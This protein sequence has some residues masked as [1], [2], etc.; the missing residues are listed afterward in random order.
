M[1]L[2]LLLLAT[3]VSPKTLPDDFTKRVWQT[4]DG[5]PE[6]MVQAFVQ[7]PDHYLWIGTTG[8]LVRFDGARFVVFDRENTPEISENSVFTLAV[9]RDGS[10]WAGPDGGGLLRY[11]DGVFRSYSASSGLLN[12]FV[13]ALYE[14][15][16]GVFWV[17]ADDGLYRMTGEKLVRVDAVRGI[18]RMAV[19]AIREDIDG[20]LWVGGSTLI[21]MR[22]SAKGADAR[23][24]TTNELARPSGAAP[25]AQ[26][27]GGV[28][29]G[30]MGT[31][32]VL[33]AFP[34]TDFQEFRLKGNDST[35]RVKSIW[36]TRDG[37]IWVGTVAR[38]QRSLG[39]RTGNPQFEEVKELTSTVRALWEDPA[40][41]LLIGSIGQGLLR[42]SDHAFH[43]VPGPDRLPSGTVLAL[44]EDSERNIWVGMQTGLLRLSPEAMSTFPL[45]GAANADFGTIYSDRDGTLW[46]A[47][48]QLF[49]ISSQRSDY[50][51]DRQ[52]PP[53]VRIRNVFRDHT[54]TLWLGTEGYGVVRIRANERTWYT[55]QNGLVNDFVRVF[56]EDRDGSVWIGTDQGVSR[57]RNGGFTTY[58]TSRGLRYRSIRDLLQDS[59]GDIWIGTERG[60]SH[61]RN[62]AFTYDEVTRKLAGEKVWTIH[63]DPAGGLWFGTRGGG[64]Y[65]WK[66]GR[67]EHFRN[68][69][70]LASNSIYKL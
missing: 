66:D 52:A 31:A 15:R 30:S 34:R 60:V 69:N 48:T 62:E 11:K 5:L 19:H 4:Q 25:S 65:R 51:L 20:S 53:R 64:L 10:L 50:E 35:A 23:R 12:P 29:R 40:G 57:W 59:R 38:L 28:V 46:V 43:P 47:G 70:G 61:W 22:G 37:T 17:G 2:A 58:D 39:N 63:E 16:N 24:Q 13:R 7:T 27:V 49:R 44:F 33:R 6:N 3:A 26:P 14:D 45:A 68:A 18:P 42:Y 21:R 56:L 55:K 32:T 41:A 9:T 36:Q 8:G 54:G 67:L 1:V